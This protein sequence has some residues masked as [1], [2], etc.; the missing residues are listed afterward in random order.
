[1]DRNETEPADWMEDADLDY[2]LE[3]HHL[4]SYGWALSCC[5]RDPV[6]AEATLQT[7]YVKVLRRQAR[8]AG[9]SSFKTWFFAVI[10]RTA[11]ER[12]RRRFLRKLR[13]V[14]FDES[15]VNIQAASESSPDGGL[16]RSE[17]QQL[18]VEALAR[19]PSRQREVLQLVF[20]HEL[21]LTECARVMAVSVG[22]ARTHYE[23]G[24]KRL[25]QLLAGTRSFNEPGSRREE[26]QGTVPRV[27]AG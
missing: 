27:E 16:Y 3:R 12:R 18:L 21:S 9:R 5:S 24:K 10:R 2:E 15:T 8:F 11:A 23:R 7:A 25:R 20:Y 19:L 17:I 6:E 26:N 1:M 13:L 14:S 4:E 22:S